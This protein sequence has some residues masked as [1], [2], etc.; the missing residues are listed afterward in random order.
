MLISISVY[1]WST[2]VELTAFLFDVKRTA[3]VVCT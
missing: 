1:G 3:D 2:G